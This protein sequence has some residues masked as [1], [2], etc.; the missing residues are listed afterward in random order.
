MVGSAA[1]GVD[2]RGFG[3][4]G[5][6]STFGLDS[7]RGLD[8]VGFGLERGCSSSLSSNGLGLVERVDW[9]LKESVV[10]LDLSLLV[11]SLLVL[12]PGLSPGLPGGL[13][14][15]LGEGLEEGLGDD[16]A[17]GSGEALS[18]ADGS[19]FLPPQ[20]VTREVTRANP[21]IARTIL[22]RA[23]DLM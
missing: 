20:A 14:V 10:I 12:S 19:G 1:R 4:A 15:G 2:S 18:T 9:G 3:A 21:A 23:I 16:V 11:L 17:R 13:P 22:G 6:D 5:L 8:S 7:V